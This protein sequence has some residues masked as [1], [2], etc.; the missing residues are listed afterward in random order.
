MGEGR[1]NSIQ[2]LPSVII[3]RTKDLIV[4]YEAIVVKQTIAHGALETTFV[5]PATVFVLLLII[6][7]H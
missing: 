6:M 4:A 3:P 1:G 7:F 5:K 2:H